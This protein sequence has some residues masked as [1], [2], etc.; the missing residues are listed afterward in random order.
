MEVLCYDRHQPHTS[1]TCHKSISRGP[2]SDTEY[3]EK[4]VCRTKANQGQEIDLLGSQGHE[5]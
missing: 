4:S 5:Y 2:T 3:S 1:E